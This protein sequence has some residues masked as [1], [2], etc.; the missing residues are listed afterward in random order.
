MNYLF[1]GTP[2]FSAHCLEVLLEH[3]FVPRAIVTN[4]DRPFGRKKILT[5]P[6]VKMTAMAWN[7]G[8]HD[9]D[10]NNHDK[11]SD[12]DYD[13]AIL[14][15]EKIDGAFREKLREFEPDLFIVFA[16]NKI[17]RQETLDIPAKGVIGVH[18]SFL[19]EY[20]GPSPF[21]TALLDGE[22]KTGVTLYLLDPGID[23]GPV[24]A[25]SNPV[26]IAPEDNFTSLAFKLADAGANLLVQTL[27]GFLAGEIKPKPQDESRA[28]YT[29]KFHTEDGFV[30]ES[31]LAAAEQGDSKKSKIIFNKI[32]AFTPEPG[33]WTI[34]SGKRLKLLEAKIENG[35]LRLMTTQ[36]EGQK[37]KS[38]GQ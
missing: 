29:K 2:D 32:R 1:F 17:L 21:Q 8:A 9:N 26:A 28:T 19:P 12:A 15:P 25:V 34:R 33:A 30:E 16:Y 20:R 7:R 13:I 24:V 22:I 31:D 18:P 14:Q 5:P 36:E 35:A 23:S 3:D 11:R 37:A 6:P 10:N 38:H 4:P 27:P